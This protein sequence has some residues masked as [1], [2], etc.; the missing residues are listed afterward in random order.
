MCEEQKYVVDD[1]NI[2]YDRSMITDVQHD[3]KAFFGFK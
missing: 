3:V 2:I 1:E